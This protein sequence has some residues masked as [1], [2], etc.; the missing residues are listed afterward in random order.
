MKRRFPALDCALR[1]ACAIW[2]GVMAGFFFAFSV[3]VMPGLAAVDSTAALRSMQGINIAVRNAPFAAGFFGAAMLSAA[4]ILRAFFRRGRGRS[5]IAATGAAVYLAG[6]FAV[7]AAFNLPLNEQ[8]AA[9][10]PAAEGGA[11]A[12]AAFT[13]EWV[14]WNHTRT[15]SALIAFALLAASLATPPRRAPAGEGDG[16][17]TQA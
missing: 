13:G 6:V 15:I 4:V 12:M 8:L 10:N 17:D 9:V 7:T 1:L 3:A 14:F 5:G 11:Q 2:A 16:G